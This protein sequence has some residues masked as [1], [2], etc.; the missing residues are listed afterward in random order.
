MWIIIAQGATLAG[1]LFV[2]VAA[3]VG[4]KWRT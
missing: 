3:I 4:A 2:P 1:W